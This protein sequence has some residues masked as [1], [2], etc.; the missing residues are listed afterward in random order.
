MNIPAWATRPYPQRQQNP[1]AADYAMGWQRG[2]PWAVDMGNRY[3]D[4]FRRHQ[5]RRRQSIQAGTDPYRLANGGYRNADRSPTYGLSWNNGQLG[6]RTR[7][8]RT[9]DPTIGGVQNFPNMNNY[10]AQYSPKPMTQMGLPDLFKT[11][12]LK[13]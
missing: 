4:A 7:D 13:V 2:G 9:L 6:Q 12:G 3:R 8:M 5:L 10:A 1:M 11:Y